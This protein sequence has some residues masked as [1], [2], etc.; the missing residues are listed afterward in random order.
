MTDAPVL[1]LALDDGAMVPA[2]PHWAKR[3]CEQ[4]KAGERYALVEHQERSSKS[5]AHYFAAVHE[6]W[7]NLPEH[8]AERFPTAEHLRKY[9]LIKTG[10]CNTSQLPCASKKAALDAAAFVRPTDEYSIVTVTGTIVTRYTARSQSYRS[11][12]HGEFQ[13]SKDEVLSLISSMIGT[14]PSELEKAGAG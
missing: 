5:H 11:M 10:Y 6:A 8:L 14:S 7:A 4:F 2:S 13:K 9:A 12:P 1:F 3:A